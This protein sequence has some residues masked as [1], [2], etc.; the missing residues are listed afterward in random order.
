MLSRE[1][2]SRPRHN[3]QAVP[4]SDW[5]TWLLLGGRGSG[6]TY[7]GAA[8][9]TERA[10]VSGQ[11]LAIVGPSLH[12]VREVMVEGPAGLK[13]LADPGERPRWEAGRRRLLWPCG[14]AA[15][16]LSLIRI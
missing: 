13:A 10:R 16:A 3:H 7:A 9:I 5:R 14:A 6:K 1:R 4:R 12:D 11:V 2:R 8:W 15:Y